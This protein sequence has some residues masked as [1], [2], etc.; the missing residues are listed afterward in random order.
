M[1]LLTAGGVWFI[2]CHI[3]ARLTFWKK[4][5]REYTPVIDLSTGITERLIHRR[6]ATITDNNYHLWRREK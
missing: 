4:A 1:N 2:G 5:P 6:R 3:G